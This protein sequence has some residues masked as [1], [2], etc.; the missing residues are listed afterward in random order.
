MTTWDSYPPDYRKKEVE[1]ILRWVCSGDCVAVIGLSG[2]GK[3]NLLGFFAN[4][5]SQR[6]GCP[7][8][9][10][11]D[12]N[13]LGENSRAAFFRHFLYSLGVSNE[14]L[15]GS[16]AGELTL[17]ERAIETRL[18][19][20]GTLCFLLDRFDALYG[21]PEFAVLANNLRAIRDSYKYQISYV[22]AARNTLDEQSELAELFFGRTIWLGSLSDSDARWSAYRDLERFSG[23]DGPVLN[24]SV[25]EKL[26]RLSWGYPSLL[27]GV[28]EAYASGAPLELEAL[29]AHPSVRRRVME[30]WS[31]RPDPE[32]VRLCGLKGQPLLDFQPMEQPNAA[33]FDAS[34]LTAKENLLLK[35]FIQHEGLVCEKDELIQA[36]WPEDVIFTQGI[37]DESLAQLIRRLRVKVEP[38][39][40][41]PAFIHTVPGRGYLYRKKIE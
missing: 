38:D 41:N 6:P 34:Q 10:L 37:R 31:D 22:I 8:V 40:G 7:I 36:V 25:M 33:S 2:S 16:A 39:P 17:L 26:I 27:R 24:E 9:M 15:A 32:A 11:V 4:R 3:S 30:F 21:W 35:Y 20:R 1:A 14:S 5:I 18:E 13:R 28:C 23:K 19:Q 29:R 12:C